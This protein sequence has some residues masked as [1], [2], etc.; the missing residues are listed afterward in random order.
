MRSSLVVPRKLTLSE[1]TP[2]SRNACI[3][4]STNPSGPTSDVAIFFAVV[5]LSE[6]LHNDLE[7]D[8]VSVSVLCPHIVDTD[9]ARIEKRKAAMPWFTDVAVKPEE[10]G[11]MVIRGIETDEFYIFCDGKASREMMEGRTQRLFDAMNR[12]FPV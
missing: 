1:V 3:R 5:G 8:N 6:F 9:T 12:Q 4:S 10:S 7:K 11:N 2:L